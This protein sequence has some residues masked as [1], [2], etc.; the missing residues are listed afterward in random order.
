MTTDRSRFLAG[1]LAACLAGA[2]FAQP[3][4]P[5]P[6]PFSSLSA[7]ERTQLKE[8][9]DVWDT[10]PP[11]K[12]DRLRRGAER[13][14]AMTPEQREKAAERFRRWQAMPPEASCY[15]RLRAG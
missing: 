4:P 12:Q 5:A 1:V 10:L 15:R 8:F 14:A 6:V 9:A 2:A 11:P 7:A 3:P 13:W